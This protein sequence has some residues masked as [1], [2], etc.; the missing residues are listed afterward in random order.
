MDLEYP[1][2]L[3]ELYNNYPLARDKIKIKREV[4]S[5]YQLT[6]PIDNDKK[7]LPN[8]FDRKKYGIHH[9]NL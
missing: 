6:N 2:E 7:L 4:L 5:N 1:K 9:E 8:F 3:Q